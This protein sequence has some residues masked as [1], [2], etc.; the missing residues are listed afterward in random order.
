MDAYTLNPLNPIEPFKG[1]LKGTL[2]WVHGAFGQACSTVTFSR[3]SCVTAARAVTGP[4]SLPERLR[5]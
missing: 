2:V 4:V 5:S 1:T 3:L